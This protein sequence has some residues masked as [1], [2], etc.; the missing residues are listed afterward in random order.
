MKNIITCPKLFSSESI[1]EAKY[2]CKE[3]M[4]VLNA[5]CYNVWKYLN[6]GNFKCMNHRCENVDANVVVRNNIMGWSAIASPYKE[7]AEIQEP[8]IC[9]LTN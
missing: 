4:R 3:V 6:P 7:V 5:G 8:I 2:V 1:D 9:P